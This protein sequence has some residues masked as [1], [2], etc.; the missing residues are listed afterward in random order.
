[1][2]GR[3]FQ[4]RPDSRRAV[5]QRDRAVARLERQPDG[6]DLRGDRPHR[7]GGNVPAPMTMPTI[8]H[9][10]SAAR[11]FTMIEALVSLVV[12]LIGLLGLASLQVV[13]VRSNHFGRKMA[14]ASVLMHDL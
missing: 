3:S 12:M 11:G 8:P 14:I 2:R 5:V 13:G 1:R 4:R 9:K 10:G 6:H 7:N